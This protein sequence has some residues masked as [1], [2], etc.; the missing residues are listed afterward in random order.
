MIHK[1]DCDKMPRLKHRKHQIFREVTKADHKPEE[2][3]AGF[4]RHPIS[5]R[6]AHI[7]LKVPPPLPSCISLREMCRDIAIS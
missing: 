2:P 5:S 6:L 1:K 4:D 7:S 3:L